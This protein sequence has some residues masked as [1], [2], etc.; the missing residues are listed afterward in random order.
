MA[1]DPRC[2]I[3]IFS[4]MPC[5]GLV[6]TTVVDYI[7]A[8]KGEREGHDERGMVAFSRLVYTYYW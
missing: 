5:G 8:L 2:S 4:K 1:N 3:L 6:E 7:L